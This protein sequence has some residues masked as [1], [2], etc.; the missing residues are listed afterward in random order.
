MDRTV[1]CLLVLSWLLQGGTLAG[2]V[3]VGAAGRIQVGDVSGIVVDGRTEQ[4]VRG[5][6]V[7]LGGPSDKP[8]RRQQTDAAGRF[9]FRDMPV[10]SY[11][12]TATKPGYFP[13]DDGLASPSAGRRRFTLAEGEWIKDARIVLWPHASIS[14]RVTDEQ[15][16]PVSDAYVRVFLRVELAAQS[17]MV[18][19]P[20]TR[21][22][23]RGA[24]TVS[25]LA[26]GEYVA[27][28]LSTQVWRPARTEQTG[29][30]GLQSSGAGDPALR[31]CPDG[32][33]LRGS[34]GYPAPPPAS[35][36]ARTV[37][38]P[39]YF[40]GVPGAADAASLA[41]DFGDS[42]ADIDFRL[43]AKAAWRVAGSLVPAPETAGLRVRLI[44]A[45]SEGLGHG[46]E[47]ATTI[48]GS[49]G[50]FC[51]PDLPAGFYTIEI[52]PARGEL[53]LSANPA[54][55]LSPSLV[56]LPSTTGVVLSPVAG[57]GV[58][59]TFAR[60]LGDPGG[61][62]GRQG[63]EVR[64]KHVDGVEVVVYA[65]SRV[66]GVLQLE[67]RATPPAHR[68]AALRL[69]PFIT[70]AVLVAP[71]PDVEAAPDTAKPWAQPRAFEFRGVTPGRYFLRTTGPG[72]IRSVDWN[73]R[74]YTHHSLEVTGSGELA[75]LVVTITT[76]TAG[77]SGT[78]TDSGG[79]AAAAAV[80]FFPQDSDGWADLG[81]APNRL[82]LAPTD[83]LG[84]YAI[85]KLTAGKYYVIAVPLESSRRWRDPEFLSTVATR[86]TR[87]EVTWGET[88]T[89]HL[90]VLK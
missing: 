24:Y 10:G 11:V 56:R 53:S 40:P 52:T 27:S 26:R 33:T 16:V 42:R 76:E 21:T 14:G 51:F 50:R 38:P 58:P 31:E 45:G 80:I 41:L 84:R 83:S 9:V 44:P 89:Q 47:A 65:A 12:A 28:V 63:V 55:L 79:P 20:V 6:I 61:Y 78:V 49:A 46:S 8:N 37:Y 60:D 22:D 70:N 81:L 66:S 36:G 71:G 13:P 88:R 62:W 1:G 68:Y 32:S 2:G 29:N 39:Q 54:A 34:G 7:A 25:G 48:A 43:E 75:G 77:I 3:A 59:L 57:A 5:A 69:E 17:R 67:P 30:R 64:D 23:D 4:P 73:G 15:G 86:A 72:V 82:G 19:G 87:V 90:R 74:D 35:G 85:S 18:A